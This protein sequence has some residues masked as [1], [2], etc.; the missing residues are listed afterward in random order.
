MPLLLNVYMLHRSNII[1]K[2]AESSFQPNAGSSEIRKPSYYIL[3]YM[4]TQY[5]RFRHIVRQKCIKLSLMVHNSLTGSWICR[6]E[7]NTES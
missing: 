6:T 3:L 2:A 5:I 7:A 1:E 4:F